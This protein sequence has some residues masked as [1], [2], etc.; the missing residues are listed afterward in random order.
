[1]SLPSLNLAGARLAR[2]AGTQMADA[3]KL[4]SKLRLGVLA[5]AV[6]AAASAAISA[7]VLS[8]IGAE[9]E[10][11]TGESL[12][13]MLALTRLDEM[14]FS[15]LAAS[16][17]LTDPRHPRSHA[18]RRIALE[19]DGRRFAAGAERLAREVDAAHGDALLDAAA[20]LEGGLAA[21]AAAEA[22]ADARRAEADA[23]LD[24]ADAALK[25]AAGRLA[26][27]REGM[28]DAGLG[29]GDAQDRPERVDAYQA[30][31]SSA[32]TL[33]FVGAVIAQ[34]RL[35]ASGPQVERIGTAQAI[36][37][38]DLARLLAR[39]PDAPERAAVAAA[40]TEL[41]RR[42]LSGALSEALAAAAAASE[43]GRA[44]G[45]ELVYTLSRARAVTVD[46]VAML[47]ASIEAEGAAL[48]ARTRSL[49][50]LVALLGLVAMLAGGAVAYGLVELLLA[51][52][53]RIVDENLHRIEE[54]DLSP[55]GRMP[56][57]ADEIARIAAAVERLR[58]GV[59]ERARLEAALQRRTEEAERHAS[60]KSEFLS[61]MSH[62]IRTPLNA[63]MG[64]FE[65]IERSDAPERQRRR[66]AHGRMASEGLYDVLSKVLDASR[67]EAG[68]LVIEPR[69]VET[70][71]LVGF[72]RASLEGAAADKGAGARFAVRTEGD[73][74]PEIRADEVRLRQILSNLVDNAVRFCP[75]GRVEAI[76]RP[77]PGAPDW[78]EF[79]IRDDGPGIP[80]ELHGQVF[81]M[82]RQAEDGITRG[83]GGSGL[84]LAISRALAELMGGALTLRSA[85]GEGASFALRLPVDAAASAKLSEA[86][87]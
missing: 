86:A 87:E 31:L 64:L 40:L 59:A 65:L 80:P 85:P 1:M 79:E 23:L 11:L 77:A 70:E 52:R 76:I 71:A 69:Q 46:A 20:E 57:G 28:R 44:Q 29:P 33:D 5:L 51:R 21:M 30:L 78:I 49:Y 26:A 82:F 73:P 36:M 75:D 62:E 39:L 54:G 48:S 24:A 53:L 34:S 68:L 25:D 43:A 61:M 58:L 67:L 66:A 42:V 50:S 35:V 9:R 45:R 15:M 56:G 55:P 27:W 32:A 38:R 18:A 7:Y 13:R 3:M 16:H 63:V 6:A 84:G 8:S 4:A 81:E 37:Q 41:R 14:T 19:R 22:R 12:P 47:R 2:P 60:A 74:P 17:V 10:R 72:L 83:A